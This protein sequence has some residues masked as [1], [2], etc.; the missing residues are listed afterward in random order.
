MF[1]GNHLSQGAAGNTKQKWKISG[2]AH[3][4]CQT[5]CVTSPR[6]SGE[7]GFS[8]TDLFCALL[9]SAYV[10]AMT[11]SPVHTAPGS[12]I[13]RR[14]CENDGLGLTRTLH[15]CTHTCQCMHAPLTLRM[16][17]ATM[18]LHAHKALS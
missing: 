2:L 13:L 1:L 8:P 17:S 5:M 15:A 3:F 10:E 11:G 4:G 6:L 9:D 18:S 7:G 16:H 14:S 12:P